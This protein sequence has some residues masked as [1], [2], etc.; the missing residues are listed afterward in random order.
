MPRI[1]SFERDRTLTSV[2]EGK[3]EIEI[4]GE[5][6]RDLYL[7]EDLRDHLTEMLVYARTRRIDAEEVQRTFS[8]I[9]KE[10]RVPI[11]EVA[12]EN[13]VQDS[14][15]KRDARKVDW[16]KEVEQQRDS[17]LTIKDY[18]TQRGISVSG[19]QRARHTKQE[20]QPLS[21]ELSPS[22][23]LDALF[24][25]AQA[26]K[27]R[28]LAYTQAGL[29]K[30]LTELHGRKDLDHHRAVELALRA[31]GVDNKREGVRMLLEILGYSSEQVTLMTDLADEIAAK[32]HNTA[33]ETITPGGPDIATVSGDGSQFVPPAESG[34]EGTGET[35]R[36][37]EPLP[38]ESK[39]RANRKTSR[40]RRRPT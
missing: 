3:R 12:V 26:L 30:A 28:R 37:S 29:A 40:R 17:G 35:S 23:A 10:A 21:Y 11:G 4:T 32:N 13:W 16:A 33:K 38:E 20:A 1:I 24:T 18:A 15:F 2:Y 7:A 9:L 36:S 34:R 14:L 22:K 39:P 25:K 19:L 27:P 6:V 5:H 8:R 31:L